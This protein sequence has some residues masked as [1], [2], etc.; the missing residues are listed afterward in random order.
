MDIK[1]KKSKP[2]LI[3]LSFFVGLSILVFLLFSGLAALVHSGSNFAVFKSSFSKDYKETPVFK[4]RTAN[5]FDQL[6][7]AATDDEPTVSPLRNLDNEG[8]NVRYYY[9]NQSTGITLDNIEGELSFKPASGLP[10]LPNIYSYFWYFDGEQL[11]VIKDGHPVDTK[12]IDSGYR[13]VTRQLMINQRHYSPADFSNIRIVL[14]V[15]DNLEENP[16]SIS[17]YYS[18]QRFISIARPIYGVLVFMALALLG[19]SLFY[20]KDK[21]RFDKMLAHWSGRV[22]IEIKAFFSFLAL[23]IL[24]ALLGKNYWLGLA[25]FT[26]EFVLN[27]AVVTLG[28]LMVGW[29]F[30]LMLV[31]LLYNRKTFFSHNLINTALT[32]YRKIESRYPWQKSMLQRAYSLLAAV[33]VLALFSVFFVLVSAGYGDFFS[34]M[35]SLILAAAGVY[36][37][38]RYMKRFQQTVGSIGQVVDHIEL[39]KHGDFDTRLELAEDDDMYRTAMNLNS[40][41]QGM[42][43]AVDEKT[44]SERM[45]VELI[46]NVSHD[47]KT[48]LTSIISYV[49]LLAK[50]EGLPEHVN[51]YIRILAQKSERLKN[52]IQ[53]LFDLSKA[54]SE[55]MA[56]EMER[57]DLVKLIQQTVADMEEQITA[58]GLTFR[59]R[60]PDQPVLIES[61]GDKLRRVWENLIANA[62]KY[63]LPGSRVYIDLITDNGQATATIKNTANYEMDFGPEDILQRFVRGD[64][65]RSTE[66]SGLGLSI[67]QSFTELCRGQFS[68]T[69]DGDL[70]K[71]ELRFNRLT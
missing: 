43:I 5:Y 6:T 28:L 18:G 62:L 50:E 30:Y 51:D 9:I 52:L 21:Q 70:F 13:E 31:D 39:I 22:W 71:V 60:M 4:E 12:R 44:R 68:I 24:L 61:D 47:L 14:A 17:D 59:I 48:P 2:I 57:L 25:P 32:W 3:W 42:S 29:W 27:V 40:I 8:D 63:S 64:E 7:Y 46:T 19:L 65:A 35:M 20:R 11:Q 69:I 41:Q 38:I 45:K 10:V 36:L 56:L 67:A 53:D 66:G 16:Y 37:I 33:T 1:S 34:L 15:K 26:P 49:D 55:N 54:T 58:S 23:I